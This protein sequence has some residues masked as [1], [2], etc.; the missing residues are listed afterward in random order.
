MLL[1]CL[2]AFELTLDIDRL[3]KEVDYDRWGQH[4]GFPWQRKVASHVHCVA[5]QAVL[6][7]QL[8]CNPFANAFLTFNYRRLW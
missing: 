5:H 4:A 6:Q 7:T 8:T 3:I 2:Q 1:W